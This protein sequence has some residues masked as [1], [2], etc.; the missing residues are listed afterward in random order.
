MFVQELQFFL[1]DNQCVSQLCSMVLYYAQNYAAQM[2]RYSFYTIAARIS[3]CALSVGVFCFLL[4]S[5]VTQN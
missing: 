3:H 4:L 1:L 5:Y 2:A